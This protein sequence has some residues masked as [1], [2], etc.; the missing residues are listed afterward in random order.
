MFSEGDFISLFDGVPKLSLWDGNITKGV[1]FLFSGVL[2]TA[3]PLDTKL[4][5]SLWD[6]LS[7]YVLIRGLLGLILT[8]NSS[9]GALSRILEL[10]CTLD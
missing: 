1:Y 5:L 8:S 4:L 10:F 6:D 9:T 3:K 7:V 2:R